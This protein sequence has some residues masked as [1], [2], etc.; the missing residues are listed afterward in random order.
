MAFLALEQIEGVLFCVLIGIGADVVEQVNSS[1]MVWDRALWVVLKSLVATCRWASMI[2]GPSLRPKYPFRGYLYPER[3]FAIK[4]YLTQG[5]SQA[6]H[7][8]KRRHPTLGRR[9]RRC[10][11]NILFFQ[12]LP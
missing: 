5:N 12:R 10:R 7:S 9:S 11:V 8:E 1:V 6:R 3:G 2:C 4:R